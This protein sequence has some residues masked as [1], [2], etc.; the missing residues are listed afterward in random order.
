[1]EIAGEFYRNTFMSNLKPNTPAWHEAAQRG[2]DVARISAIA[3]A[4]ACGLDPSIAAHTAG[5]AAENNAFDPK[6]L[7]K[8][9]MRDLQGGSCGRGVYHSSV[10]R[11]SSASSRAQKATPDASS[12]TKVHKNSKNYKGK[13]VVYAIRRADGSID[14][15]GESAQGL[16]VKDGAS[17]RAEQQVRAK[18]REG[19]PCKSEI[20]KTFDS[21]QEARDYE[22][23]L[24]KRFRRM[25]GKD[26]LPGNKND[27]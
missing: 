19:N 25:F 8:A 9:M 20:R 7:D 17:I 4:T 15:I 26:K 14:K 5:Q 27:R 21:K 6:A 13:T 12:A 2:A 18:T 11:A 10:P 23:K 24:I 22:T 16:R 3:F 1:G